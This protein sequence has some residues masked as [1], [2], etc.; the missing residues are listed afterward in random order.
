[1]AGIV[2][3]IKKHGPMSY[4]SLVIGVVLFCIVFIEPIRIAYV[5]SLLGDYVVF[6]LSVLG[7]LL[8]IIGIMKKAERKKDHS[9]YF[10]DFIVISL[11]TLDVCLYIADD[12]N[13]AI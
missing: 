13:L 10:T 5:G 7:V 1:M 4:L 6:F 8:S 9:N 3:S 12:G 2:Q 11:L